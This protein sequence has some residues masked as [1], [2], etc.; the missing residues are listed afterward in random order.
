MILT[1]FLKQKIIED[2]KDQ[3]VFSFETKDYVAIKTH[4]IN[5]FKMKIS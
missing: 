1:G 3:R 2:K 4:I 5:N